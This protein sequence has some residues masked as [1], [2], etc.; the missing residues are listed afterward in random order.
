MKNLTI[1]EN[2]LKNIIVSDK[3]ENPIR[4]ERVLKSE[5]LNVIKNYFEV[6]SDD[7]ELSI[8]V[9]D[10]GRYDVQMNVLSRAIRFANSFENLS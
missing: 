5:L 10:D 7:L 9:R 3:R 1:C 2:R 6:T 4:I 8:L